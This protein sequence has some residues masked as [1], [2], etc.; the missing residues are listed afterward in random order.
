MWRWEGAGQGRR[1]RALTWRRPAHHPEQPCGR[2][3]ALALELA[4]WADEGGLRALSLTQESCMGPGKSGSGYAP[5]HL[6][7]AVKGESCMG[8]SGVPTD[9]IPLHRCAHYKP[10]HAR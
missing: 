2:H 10:A 3:Q 6:P 7:Q 8:N 1:G 9:C 4:A 5:S